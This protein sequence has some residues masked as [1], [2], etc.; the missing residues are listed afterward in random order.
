MRR[1]ALSESLFIVVDMGS[2]RVR[3][4]VIYVPADG[5]YEQHANTCMDHCRRAGLDVI[6]IAPP[7]DWAAIERTTLTDRAV[8]ALVIARRDHLPPGLPELIVVSEAPPFSAAA[9]HRNQASQRTRRP[10]RL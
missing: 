7:G 8:D 5:P 3:K 4:V 9:R 1:R 10:K 2:V 6:G